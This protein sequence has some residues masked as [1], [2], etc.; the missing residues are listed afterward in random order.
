MRSL[1]FLVVLSCVVTAQ[2][3]IVTKAVSYHAG[4]TVMEGFMAYDDSK[5][6]RPCVLICHDWDG[7][8]DHE[9]D[10]AQ[11]IAKLGYTAF[12]IDVYG[13]GVH[14]KTVDDFSK[15]SGKYKNDRLEVRTRTNAA[16]L[17]AMGQPQVDKKRVAAIGYCFGGMVALEMAR[18]A[19][20]LKGAVSFHGDVSN[21]NPA[22]DKNIKC[23]IL[24]LHGADDPFVTKKDVMAYD[25][26][27]A[28]DKKPHWIYMYPKAVHAFTVKSAGNLHLKGAAYDANADKQSWAEM[29]KFFKKIF[30]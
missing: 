21:P 26:V 28:K 30:K 5:G 19:A 10:V 4:G 8:N 23:P 24:I 1:A 2:A 16:L 29:L 15:E 22:S 6:K 18:N 27:L 17:Y 11:R 3:K 20:P 7:L 9:K 12:A 25:K 13:R 14:L